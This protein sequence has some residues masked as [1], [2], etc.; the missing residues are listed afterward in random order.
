MSMDICIEKNQYTR[1]LDE[2][3]ITKD[4]KGWYTLMVKEL[5]AFLACLLYVDM[6]KLPNR[7]AYWTKRNNFFYCHIIARIFTRKWYMALIRCLHITPM[8]NKR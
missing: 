4:S 2:A 5:K 3:G 6:K 1:L 7:K 8:F